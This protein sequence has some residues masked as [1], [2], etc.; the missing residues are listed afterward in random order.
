MLRDVRSKWLFLISKKLELVGTQCLIAYELAC[1]H[2]SVSTYDKMP[3]TLDKFFEDK[4]RKKTKHLM[5]IRFAS[6][7]TQL[8]Y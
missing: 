4:Q 8:Q 1:V 6:S 5:I 3:L 7:E 2:L